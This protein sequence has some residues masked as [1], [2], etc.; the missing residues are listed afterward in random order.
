MPNNDYLYNTAPPPQYQGRYATDVNDTLVNNNNKGFSQVPENNGDSALFQN[1]YKESPREQFAKQRER[2]VANRKKAQEESESTGSAD[3]SESVNKYKDY[4]DT[5]K[6]VFDTGKSLLDS[7]NTA[8]TATQAASTIGGAA[9]ASQGVVASSAPLGVSPSFGAPAWGSSGSA[10]LGAATNP[11]AIAPSAGNAVWGSGAAA[12]TQTA[13]SSTS[14]AASAGA[15]IGTA[16]IGAGL[17]IGGAA[18]GN[19]IRSQGTDDLG[20]I[21]DVSARHGDAFQGAGT[22]AALGLTVGG[23]IGAL[24][25]GLIGGIGGLI[26]SGGGNEK[27]MNEGFRNSN[28]NILKSNNYNRQQRDNGL[29]KR[30]K[31]NGTSSGGF[32]A[33]YGGDIPSPEYTVEDN[34]TMYAPDG[35]PPRTN[36]NGEAQK[37]GDNTYKFKGDKHSDPSGGIGV[38]GGNT[39]FVGSY[40]TPKSSGFVFSNALKADASKYLKGL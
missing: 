29:L 11:A 5:G 36:G 9:T 30:Y 32:Y 10:A 14:T 40:G 26:F 1:G 34:E 39:P 13:T 38:V 6:Q 23:P 28:A 15:G 35:N 21:D 18:A 16:A 17:A 31:T 33:K 2:M 37:I 27:E 25:G 3:I 4:Y 19:K 7:Y 22:G 12:T 8:R 20:R 24:A